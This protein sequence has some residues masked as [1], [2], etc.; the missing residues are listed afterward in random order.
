MRIIIAPDSFKG[1]LSAKQATLAMEKGIR[2]AI[3][4][5]DLE[6]IR[7]PMADGGE[8]TVEAFIEAAGGDIIADNVLDPLGR[9]VASFY[10]ILPDHTAVIEMA[11]ASG[12]NLIG[13]RE[14]DPLKTTTYGTG[15]LILSALQ[16]GCQK[17]IIGIGGSATNDCGAGMA[18]ALGVKLLD[19]SGRE[20]GFGGGILDQVAEIDGSGLHP[21]LKTAKFTIACDVKN[22]L[23]GTEGASYVYGPQKGATPDMVQTLDANLRHFAGKL[24]QCTG[25]DVLDVPGSGAAGGLGA[26]LFAF[27]DA[28]IK[29]GVEIVME[30][31]DL[32]EKI[33]TADFVIT[34]EGATDYQSMF[35]K[36][37]F[38]I[39][40]KAKKLGKPVLCVS[41]TL[42]AGY[43]K[44]YDI[45]ITAFFS[46][47]NKPMTLEEAIEGGEE[48]LEQ[49][50]EN[51]FR[52]IDRTNRRL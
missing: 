2:K 21:G 41:G 47:V 43:D 24:Q 50:V 10:G 12:L 51:V 30:V 17:F 11:A 27:L 14:R 28:D 37:P 45:G 5:G 42:G 33:K 4:D 36:V 35:G 29:P 34:G 31:V 38:G 26:G 25:K 15:Q 22:P 32:E 48:L 3:R 52:I 23:C 1:S 9:S 7:I 46:I 18:Q 39:A 8:G 6:I 49:A 16:R 40:S 20:V 19:R 44:L 13:S